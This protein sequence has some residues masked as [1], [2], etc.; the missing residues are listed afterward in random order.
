[1]ADNE[2]TWVGLLKD[3]L[4]TVTKPLG[5]DIIIEEDKHRF[6]IKLNYV[7]EIQVSFIDVEDKSINQLKKY[8]KNIMSVIK[9]FNKSKIRS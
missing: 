8:I 2:V 5:L 3:D 4:E 1:M 9:K 6:K 7:Y